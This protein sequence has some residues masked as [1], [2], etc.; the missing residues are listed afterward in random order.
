MMSPWKLWKKFFVSPRRFV[1][2]DNSL[3]FAQLGQTRWMRE[4]SVV[5]ASHLVQPSGGLLCR[6]ID[7]VIDKEF[8]ENNS[9][10]VPIF[11]RNRKSCDDLWRMSWVDLDCI[12]DGDVSV[13]SSKENL[14]NLFSD[15]KT[16]IRHFTN[17]RLVIGNGLIGLKLAAS[18][19]LLGST[20]I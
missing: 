9:N 10:S 16:Y 2:I 14:C 17:R 19:F 7:K 4:V 20:K 11:S 8:W 5:D 12:D 3:E 15:G 6:I 18:H 1:H 13:R